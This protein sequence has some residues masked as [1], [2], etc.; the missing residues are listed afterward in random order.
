VPLPE[1]ECASAGE[2]TIL[3]LPPGAVKCRERLGGAL[4]HYY[5]IA[6]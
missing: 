6:A 3:M 2:P 1:A 5:R 4:K